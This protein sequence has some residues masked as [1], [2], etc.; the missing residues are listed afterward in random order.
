[1]DMN[2]V[3]GWLGAGVLVVA[4]IKT[5]PAIIAAFL[6]ITLTKR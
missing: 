5:L 4:I 6:L 3:I 1:M 2:D